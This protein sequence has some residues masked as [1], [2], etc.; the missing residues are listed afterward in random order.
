M[1]LWGRESNQSIF[2]S[3]PPHNWDKG[4]PYR[5]YTGIYFYIKNARQEYLAF[6]KLIETKS[7]GQGRAIVAENNTFEISV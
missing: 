3:M 1:N 5:Y 6:S 2:G 4:L 7:S